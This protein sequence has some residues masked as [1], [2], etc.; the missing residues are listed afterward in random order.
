MLKPFR[1]FVGPL[2]LI[3]VLGLALATVACGARG[4]DDGQKRLV[5]LRFTHAAVLHDVRTVL[6]LGPDAKT[7]YELTFQRW[8][9]FNRAGSAV[10]SCK[11]NDVGPIFTVPSGPCF[12]ICI[13]GTPRKVS[14]G[15]NRLSFPLGSLF[16]TVTSARPFQVTG[17]AYTSTG[18]GEG[19]AGKV[20]LAYKVAFPL[21]ADCGPRLSVS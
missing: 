9:G 1:F 11:S 6:R 2:A 16:L 4:A 14:D 10:R 18:G 8:H 19:L 13:W 7:D 3:C 15:P 21:R 20:R 17:L 5:A 12:R